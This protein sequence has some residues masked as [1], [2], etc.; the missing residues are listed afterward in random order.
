MQIW[1]KDMTN[2]DIRKYGSDKHDALGISEDGRCLYYENF[3]NGDGSEY[4]DYRFVN[5]DGTL[6]AETKVP[7]DC[8]A[9]IGGS[10]EDMQNH[11]KNDELIRSMVLES[12]LLKPVFGTSRAECLDKAKEIICKD[13]ENTYGKPENNF[14]LIAKMWRAYLG[15][16]DIS[17][18]DVAMMMSLLKIA[19]IKTGKYKAD[20]YID[21][22]G[23]SACACELG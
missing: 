1:I 3:Q 19:R 12:Q 9:N 5:S 14:E 15:N 23:Y 20:N 4:G 7:C 8:Y 21:L 2:G 16:D 13:R 10:K 22:A 17:A 11:I 18:G 6:P